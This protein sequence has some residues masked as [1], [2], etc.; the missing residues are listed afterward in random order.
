MEGRQ[1]DTLKAIEERR[2]VKH[3]DADFKIPD[4]EVNRLEEL[5]ALS[6]TAFNIQNWRIVKVTDPEL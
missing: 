4:E 2:A 5:L 6:P 3:Y 1:M